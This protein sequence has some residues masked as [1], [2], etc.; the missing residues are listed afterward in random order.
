MVTINHFVL[1][2]AVSDVFVATE[3]QAADV[4]SEETDMASE[5]GEEREVSQAQSET[6]LP[7]TNGQPPHGDFLSLHACVA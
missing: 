7:F 1:L 6:T 4:G 2:V 3:R 5:H